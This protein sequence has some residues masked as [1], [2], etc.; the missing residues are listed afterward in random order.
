MRLKNEGVTTQELIPVFP[1]LSFVNYYSLMTGKYRHFTI[2]LQDLYFQMS[3]VIKAHSSNI[4]FC[5][6]AG[7]WRYRLPTRL[8]LSLASGR[9][10]ILGGAF[11]SGSRGMLHSVDISES[12]KSSNETSE[13]GRLATPR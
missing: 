5:T 6:F 4:A 11:Y 2:T 9:K 1:S 3:A 13:I 8:W 7:V 10:S 12:C